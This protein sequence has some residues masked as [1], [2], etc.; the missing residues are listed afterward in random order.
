MSDLP[1]WRD[2]WV[3]EPLTKEKLEKVLRNLWPPK[4]LEARTLFES[5]ANVA[6]MAEDI[7]SDPVLAK[8]YRINR[9][10]EGR[11]ISIEW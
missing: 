11:V 1:R 8:Q 2:R 3:S 7:E 5:P 4:P 9:D 10:A 6:R